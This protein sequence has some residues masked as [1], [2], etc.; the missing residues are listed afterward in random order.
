M[1]SDFLLEID[2]I[3]G[4]SKDKKHQDTIEVASFSWGISNQ[5]SHASNAG[6]GAGKASFQDIHFTSSVGKASANLA[7]SCA[8]GKHIKKAVL[9]VR[10]QGETQ[11]DYYVVTLEDLL[12][13]SYQSG[14]HAGGSS[15]P[16]DQF[17]LNYAKIK[18]EYKPQK[19]DGSLDAPITMTWDVKA[20]HK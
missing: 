4:E 12:V 19:Q 13:S 20:N 10:K 16:T 11:Q 1:A 15:I 2:G 18:Y 5:G 14:D 8:S 6:G 17:S 9:Y 3:K 7:L